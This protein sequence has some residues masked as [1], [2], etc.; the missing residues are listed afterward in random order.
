MKLELIPLYSV[1]CGFC[2]C[3]GIIYPMLK[4][5]SY[6]YDNYSNISEVEKEWMNKLSAEDLLE[7]STNYVKL[8][9]KK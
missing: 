3:C 5:G 4:D 1:G 7:L 2:T 9:D 6:D 8:N